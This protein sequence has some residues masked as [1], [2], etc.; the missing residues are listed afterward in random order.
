VL[1]KGT[2]LA[3]ALAVPEAREEIFAKF[4]NFSFWRFFISGQ[5][6][7]LISWALTVRSIPLEQGGSN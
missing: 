1:S 7:T 6:I 5:V 2:L 3:E 4:A